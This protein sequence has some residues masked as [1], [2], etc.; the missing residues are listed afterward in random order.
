[1]TIAQATVNQKNEPALAAEP[2]Y[3]TL[4]TAF[5]PH[6]E[7][8]LFDAQVRNASIKLLESIYQ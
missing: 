5:T 6:Q 7:V 8:P 2:A 1:M 3:K 4:V